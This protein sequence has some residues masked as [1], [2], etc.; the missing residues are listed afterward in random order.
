MAAGVRFT[1]GVVGLVAALGLV[2][3]SFGQ[4]N[5]LEQPE[6]GE[7]LA[8]SGEVELVE[9]RLQR[10]RRGR[11]PFDQEAA[12]GTLE[13]CLWF[14]KEWQK[15]ASFRQ[16]ANPDFYFFNVIELGEVLDDAGKLLFGERTK[17]DGLP[18]RWMSSESMYLNRSPSRKG[19]VLRLTL[20]APALQAKKLARIT[21]T[22]EVSAARL[23]QQ[24]LKVPVKEGEQVFDKDIF[25]AFPLHLKVAS[26]EKETVLHLKT[27]TFLGRLSQW[28]VET[29][30]R[31]LFAYSSLPSEASKDGTTTQARKYKGPLGDDWRL[32]VSMLD[33]VESKTFQF[34]FRDIELP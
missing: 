9:L 15:S 12:K 3:A 31:P 7:P 19:P 21:G 11:I 17:E 6:V 28:E 29:K 14:P 22:V 2:S 4:P 16:E 1:A 30:G 20:K 26:Q 23:V 13:T 24:T 10:S 8:V 5:P 34:D 18:R 27:P 33:P 32:R 25:A